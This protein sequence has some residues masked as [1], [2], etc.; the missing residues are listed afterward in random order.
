MRLGKTRNM[1]D[2]R[3]AKPLHGGRARKADSK[4]NTSAYKEWTVGSPS[5]E[6]RIA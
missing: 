1:A 5:K 3:K 6:R 2:K 4:Q